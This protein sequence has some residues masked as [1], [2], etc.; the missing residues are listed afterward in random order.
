MAVAL[1]SLVPDSRLAFQAWSQ[2]RIPA[3]GE[4][5]EAGRPSAAGES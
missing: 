1:A 4:T 3:A 2:V 5:K